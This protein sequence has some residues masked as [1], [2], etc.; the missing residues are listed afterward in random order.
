MKKVVLVL[1]VFFLLA[2]CTQVKI[3]YIDID[4]VLKEYKG[5]KV[6]ETEIKTESEKIAT[7]VEQLTVVFQQKVQEYQKNIKSLSAKARQEK[8]QELMQEQQQIQQ[9]QQMVQQQ[10]QAL[11]QTKIEELNEEIE[12]FL[13]GY[14]KSKGFTYILGTSQQTKTVMYGEKTLD[15]TDDVLEALNDQYK[16]NE[17][18][19][20][21]KSEEKPE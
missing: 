7:E 15:V 13:K 6:A 17:N 14:A 20:D 21:E 18:K 19:S 3:A 10:I 9:A 8:E 4:E 12:S 2:S 5:S 16:S 11:G 1:S